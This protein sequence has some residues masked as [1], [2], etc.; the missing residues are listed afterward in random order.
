MVNWAAN[1]LEEY[2]AV[3]EAQTN[4]GNNMQRII[5]SAPPPQNLFKI[6]VDGT[7]AIANKKAGVDV[8]VRDELG[9]MEATMC[10]NLNAPLCAI[11]AKSKA[12]EV[13]LLFT[14]D[15]GIQD[16]VVES[17]SLITVQALNG[18]STP[19][20]AV[21][22]IVQ[23]IMDLSKGFRRVEVSHVKRQRYKPAHL[24]AKHALGIVD[25]IAWIEETPCFLEQALIHNV[26]I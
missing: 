2:S 9:R 6:N 16:I 23:G 7:V 10:R 8:I 22:A 17:D 24:L 21:L 4:F 11:E 25:F 15:I 26:T 1:Y 3:T 12:V 5:T 14:Q 13:G 20:S 18:T 19:P